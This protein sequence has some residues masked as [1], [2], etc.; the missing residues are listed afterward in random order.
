MRFQKQAIA[1]I[2]VLILAGCASKSDFEIMQ[3]DMGELKNRY[4]ALEKDFEGLKSETI[5][6]TEKALKE[7]RKQIESLHKG[8][9]DLQAALD[10][11]RVD[12]QALAGKADTAMQTAK[13]PEEDISLLK[14]QMVR[15]LTALEGMTDK[16]EKNL[17]DLQ[18]QMT[19]ASAALVELSPEA[20]Y[21][22]GLDAF[23]GGNPQKA[24]ELLKKFLEQHPNHG[25]AANAHYW[26]G[27]AYY[28]GK[29]YDQAVLEFDKVI[30]NYPG[31]EKVPAAM[32]KQAMS[33]KGLGDVKNARYLLKK[34]LKSY[35]RAEEARSA[36][37]QLKK[38]K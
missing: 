30:R 17:G 28:T 1:A 23:K 12:M 25:L 34:L 29:N 26:L 7:E 14:E 22:Q 27:E 36:K 21:Q 19:A 18:N 9:A 5:E 37:A 35:P 8:A 38:L 6:G 3:H 13:K 20:L 16:L 11:A 4:L 10:S 24:Q 32:L 33:F 31:K 2:F 15:R